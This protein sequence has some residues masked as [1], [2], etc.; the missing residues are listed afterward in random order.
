M[1]CPGLSVAGKVA[2]DN[3]N[4]APASVTEL[5]VTADVP[6]DVSVNESFE[7]VFRVTF[8]NASAPELTL[9]FGELEEIPVP[10]SDTVLELPLDES[11]EMLILPLAVPATVGL[12][13]T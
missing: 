10:F 11:L 9:K 7:F 8:P 6:E 2:P 3:V 1:D 13:S 5:T 4:S 12:K